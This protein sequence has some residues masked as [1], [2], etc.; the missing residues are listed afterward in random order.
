[1]I[2]SPAKKSLKTVAL[3]IARFGFT[4]VPP[5][6]GDSGS[7][8]C[9]LNTLLKPKSNQKL[10]LK[11]DKNVIDQCFRE[12]A[13]QQYAL[14]NNKLK[15]ALSDVRTLRSCLRKYLLTRHPG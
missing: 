12:Q 11:H 7:Y 9:W 14:D 8:R 15:Q 13:M 10:L 3:P 6:N 1:M 2:M 5:L 4:D